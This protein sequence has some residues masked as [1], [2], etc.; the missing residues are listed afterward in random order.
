MAT[1]WFYCI[2]HLFKHFIIDAVVTHK[3]LLSQWC[4]KKKNQ[5]TH[6]V[7][8]ATS[9]QSAVQNVTKFKAEV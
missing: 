4:K 7:V 5:V 9:Q 6:I 3:V 1:L 2:Q 8:L